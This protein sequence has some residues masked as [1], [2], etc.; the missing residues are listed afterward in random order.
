MKKKKQKKIEN[1]FKS[2]DAGGLIGWTTTFRITISFFV[3]ETQ[4]LFWKPEETESNEV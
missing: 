1:V 4:F 2:K 3:I